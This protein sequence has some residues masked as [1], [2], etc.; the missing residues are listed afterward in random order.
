MYAFFHKQ[1]L[2]VNPAFL[3]AE[4]GWTK[5]NDFP[6]LITAKKIIIMLFDFSHLINYTFTRSDTTHSLS[7]PG[8]KNAHM[9]PPYLQCSSFLIRDS[10][11]LCF[12][13]LSQSPSTFY[14]SL[15]TISTSHYLC[16]SDSSSEH[17]YLNRNSHWKINNQ[18]RKVEELTLEPSQTCQAR[19]SE[20]SKESKVSKMYLNSYQARGS[21]TEIMVEKQQTYVL[22]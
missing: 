1:T 11:V 7:F 2:G 4:K 20:V 3:R 18:K 14:S 12:L 22:E 21:Q 8:F 17:G 9:L 6:L 19:W 5:W 10:T 15:L 13:P 16:V